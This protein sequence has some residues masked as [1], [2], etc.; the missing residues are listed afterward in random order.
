MVDVLQIGS[1]PDPARRIRQRQGEKIRKTRQLRQ[2]SPAEL[3]EHVGV[4]VSAISHW[5]TGRFAPRQHHQIAIA[6]AL[7]VPHTMIFGLDAE[8]S[9]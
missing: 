2:M 7:D 4:D 3:A 8:A 5:E 9:A 6:K 1:E